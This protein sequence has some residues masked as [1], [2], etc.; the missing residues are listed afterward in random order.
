M[1]RATDC[2]S[3]ITVALKKARVSLRV[4][5]TLL[6]HEARVMMLLSGHKSIPKVFAYGRVAHFEMLSMQ[7]L[8]RSLDKVIEDMVSLP[9]ATVT[10]IAEQMVRIGTH[11]CLDEK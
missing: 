4:K 5:H 11:E 9:L 1:Y 3:G 7:L 10:N 8:S 2:D 6:D